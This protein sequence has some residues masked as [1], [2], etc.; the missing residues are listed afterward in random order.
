MFHLFR[1]NAGRFGFEGRTLRKNNISLLILDERWN[2][3]FASTPKTPQIEACEEKLKQLL[4][5]EAGLT[6]EAKEIA[7][8][9][10]LNMDKI[11]KL[12]PL[13]FE[14]NDEEA[15]KEMQLCEREI[16]RINERTKRIKEVL[17]ALPDRLKKANLELLENTVNVVYFKIRKSS[18]RIEELGKLIDETKARL[19]QYIDEKELLSQDDTD[20]YAYFHDLLGAEELERLDRRFFK[21]S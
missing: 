21:Q 11:I 9:K 10:K 1:K 17:E 19:K 18:K 6:A 12:T 13:V 4:K 8:S 16:K 7:A 2:K 5:E 14:Q 20:I 3:L 15:K